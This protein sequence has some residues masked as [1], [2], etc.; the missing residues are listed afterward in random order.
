MDNLGVHL[1]FKG[2]RVD[3]QMILSSDEFKKETGALFR[4]RITWTFN[5]DG[6][7]RQLWEILKDEI[8]ESVAFDGIFRKMK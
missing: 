4:N 1:K 2:N 7:V 8:I 3:N 5:K 6:T